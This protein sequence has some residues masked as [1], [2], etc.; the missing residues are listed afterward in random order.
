MNTI[1]KENSKL[2]T[3]IEFKKDGNGR[4]G[5][6]YKQGNGH[7]EDVLNCEWFKTEKEAIK[8]ANK[9]LL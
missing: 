3:R 9:Q 1:F 4:I 5:A 6:F 8:W 7:S 2:N